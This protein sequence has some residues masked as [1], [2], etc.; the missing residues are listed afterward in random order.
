MK[1]VAKF[2]Y[3]GGSHDVWCIFVK[4]MFGLLV[5]FVLKGLGC[6]SIIQTLFD[7]CWNSQNS[8]ATQNQTDL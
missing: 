8:I 7:K 6:V 2:C 4:A 5:V 3:C 1:L